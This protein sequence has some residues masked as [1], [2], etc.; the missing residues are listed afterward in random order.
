VALNFAGSNFCDFSVFF[1]IRK[2]K[3]PQKKLPQIFS[4]QKF[5][6]LYKNTDLKEK[7]P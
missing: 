6:P 2:N 4:P 7:M 1:V 5:T 3:F